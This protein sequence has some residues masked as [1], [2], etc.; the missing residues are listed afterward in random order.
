MASRPESVEQLLA[1]NVIHLLRNLLTDVSPAIQQNSAIAIGRLAAHDAKI[2][3]LLV[4][5]DIIRILLFFNM[6]KSNVNIFTIS[7][8]SMVSMEELMMAVLICLQRY[9]KRAALMAIRSVVKHSPELAKAVIDLGGLEQIVASLEE[10]DPSVKE[11]CAWVLGY[12]ARHDQ[13]LAY[14]VIA[15]GKISRAEAE[16]LAK[17]VHKIFPRQERFH[18]WFYA[19][20][21][22]KL[23]SER[24]QLRL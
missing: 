8:I 2:A 13:K 24:W 17:Y 22:L 1:G 20:K 7:I 23:P 16:Y 12:I 6:D 10:F 4:Q 19:S 11:G 5:Q 9:L 15:A 14:Q 18:C 3:D 21:N